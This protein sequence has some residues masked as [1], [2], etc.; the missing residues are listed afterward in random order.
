MALGV[1]EGRQ[2]LI[3]SHEH[4]VKLGS[5][6]LEEVRRDTNEIPHHNHLAKEFE[7]LQ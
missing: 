5:N 7:F 6:I 2:K 4:G 1:A 3:L